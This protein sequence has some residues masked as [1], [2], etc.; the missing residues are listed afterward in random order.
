MT[1]AL[2]VCPATDSMEL[3]EFV[4]TPLGA[5][6]HGCSR[7]RPPT[8]LACRRGC[9][10]GARCNLARGQPVFDVE[11]EVGDDTDVEIEIGL[12]VPVMRNR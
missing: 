7:F 1:R 2:V 3:I 4:E 8:A 6:L 5:L 10:Q 12:M 9:A 11:D